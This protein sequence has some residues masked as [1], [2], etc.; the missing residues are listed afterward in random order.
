MLLDGRIA[1]IDTRE[2]VLTQPRTIEIARQVGMSNLIPGEIAAERGDGY[3]FVEVDREHR[4][5]AS[6]DHAPGTPVC[7]GVRPEHLKLDV[8]RGDG[9]AI[10]KARVRNIVSDGVTATLFLDWAGFELRTHLIAGRGLARSVEVGDTILLSVR[11]EHVHI[12]PQRFG[13]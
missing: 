1:Q 3:G 7:A 12:I 13:S 9:I 6:G 5:P 4:I 10:G 8:G 2:R 11:P